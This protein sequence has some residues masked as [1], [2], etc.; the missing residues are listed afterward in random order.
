MLTVVSN[1]PDTGTTL[2]YPA[3]SAFAEGES[4][5]L[6]ARPAA[7]YVFSHWSGQTEGI[8]DVNQ[9]PVTFLMGDRLD[10][11][12]EIIANF[13][14]SDIKHSLAAFADPS[15]G[16]SLRLEPE[17]PEGG[18]PINQVV[19]VTA[20]AQT[21]YVFIRWMGDVSAYDNP[22]SL[23]VNEDKSLTAMFNPIL[24]VSCSPAAGGSV[25][26]VPES[27]RG[28]PDGSELTLTATANEGYRFVSWEGDASGSGESIKVTVN[29]PM[30]ITATFEAESASL[31]WLWI[32]LGVLV[33]LI[34]AVVVLRLLSARR[35]YWPEE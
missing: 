25:V 27:S 1:P 14:E 7:G 13:V 6:T 9:N 28:Y 29:G 32:V 30:V 20:I 34:G 5:T 11:K 12:R 23:L 22:A 31:S 33:A 24:E 18:Y 10:N 19:S 15:G 8:T 16:G 17:Q 4:V 3:R 2:I 21:K 26:R 35:T